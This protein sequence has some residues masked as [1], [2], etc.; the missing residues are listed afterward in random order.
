MIYR[1]MLVVTFVVWFSV[2]AHAKAVN[3][4]DAMGRSIGRIELRP[5]ETRFFDLLFRALPGCTPKDLGYTELSIEEQI[6]SVEITNKKVLFWYGHSWKNKIGKPVLS[7]PKNEIMKVLS[8]KEAEG[9]VLN[10]IQQCK[11]EAQGQLK[12]LFGSSMHNR[13]LKSGF[14]VLLL[15]SKRYNVVMYSFPEIISQ[16]RT[17]LD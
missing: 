13:Y 16:V 12:S 17:A 1:I 8:G 10:D 11:S 14:D 15:V 4:E 5:D 7:I 6:G 9:F 2:I 3:F